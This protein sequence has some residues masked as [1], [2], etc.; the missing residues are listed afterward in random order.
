MRRSGVA[1][2]RC[3][4][5]SAGWRRCVRTLRSPREQTSQ[6][7]TRGRPC[8][9][10]VDIDGGA[11]VVNRSTWSASVVAVCLILIGC[12]GAGSPGSSGSPDQGGSGTTPTEAS[13]EVT[14]LLVGWP[15]ADGTDPT[16]GEPVR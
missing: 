3:G 8:Y 4:T 6:S 1:T 5:V 9:S 13:G 15:D 10:S 12:T 16:T 11:A 14:A 7:G 2:S